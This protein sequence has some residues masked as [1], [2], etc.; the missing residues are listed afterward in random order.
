MFP[1]ARDGAVGVAIVAIEG[2]WLL[3][4]AAAAVACSRSSQI[5]SVATAAGSYNIA[6]AVL[7]FR[8]DS[9][10]ELNTLHLEKP[11]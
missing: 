3:I 6:G 1:V 5:K 4:A 11:K 9:L 7:Y 2:R 10:E 8:C